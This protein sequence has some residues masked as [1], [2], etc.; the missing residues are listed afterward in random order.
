[1][2]S[3]VLIA[4]SA[5]FLAAPTG[6]F[7]QPYFY[8]GIPDAQEYLNFVGGS[9]VSASYG[10]QVG[11]YLGHFQNDPTTAQFS[12]YCVDYNHYAKSGDVN[13]AQ[14]A[15]GNLGTTRLGNYATYRQA[16]YL[17]SLF[18]TLPQEQW[19]TLHAAI[20]TLTSGVTPGGNTGDFLTVAY[21]APVSFSTQGWYVV[22]PDPIYQPN[23]DGT[24]DRSGQEFLMR[25]VSVPEPSTLLL[26]GTGL[27]LFLV[28]G[29]RRREFM[30]EHA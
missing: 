22:S 24:R 4:L 7:A 27:V 1:M 28:A 20:W 5:G 11:P 2:K 25:S 26:L 30:E 23:Y 9:G 17:A 12:I 16:A 29:R 6:L 8:E 15:D 21:A 14:L 3:L 18:D 19:G 13:V 10:V